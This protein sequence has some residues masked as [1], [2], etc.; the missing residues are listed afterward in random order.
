MK[1]CKNQQTVT[2]IC[3]LEFCGAK[4]C[5]HQERIEK[6]CIGEICSYKLCPCKRCIFEIYIRKIR[7]AEIY[8]VQIKGARYLCGGPVAT[9]ILLLRSENELHCCT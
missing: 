8:V 3:A 2:K 9:N 7:K 6:V 4:V 5:V 1:I